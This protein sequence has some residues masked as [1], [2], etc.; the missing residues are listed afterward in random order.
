MLEKKEYMA[1]PKAGLKM[2]D[3]ARS[4]EKSHGGLTSD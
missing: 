4:E 1:N 3:P 2:I